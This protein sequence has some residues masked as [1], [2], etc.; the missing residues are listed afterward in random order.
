LTVYNILL[1]LLRATKED[2]G[3]IWPK[4]RLFKASY[5]KKGIES[6]IKEFILKEKVK[7]IKVR[8]NSLDN[9]KKANKL[10]IKLF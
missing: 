5:K 2:K 8:I 10:M 6:V 9:L 4:K 3:F 7:L 1:L